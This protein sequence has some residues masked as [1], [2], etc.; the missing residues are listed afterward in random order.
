MPCTSE[1]TNK[2]SSEYH[3][4]SLQQMP[5]RCYNMVDIDR[6]FPRF[7]EAQAALAEGVHD[8]L[9]GWTG[10]WKS[11]YFVLEAGGRLVY[12]NSE[13]QRVHT[14][15]AKLSLAISSQAIITVSTCA[16]DGRSIIKVVSKDTCGNRRSILM[17]FRDKVAFEQWL[18]ILSETQR[19]VRYVSYRNM[20][21]MI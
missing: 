4:R 2:T 6:L 16:S 7:P 15:K 12:Y 11:R 8:K 20:D 5:H 9:C 10:G 14:K 18:L 21:D 1:Q 17:G 3:S 19:R 13:S